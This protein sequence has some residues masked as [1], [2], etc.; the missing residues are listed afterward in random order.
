MKEV[1]IFPSKK[2]LFTDHRKRRLVRD[3][4]DFLCRCAPGKKWLLC[5]HK[6][7]AHRR[8]STVCLSSGIP[9]AASHRWETLHSFSAL[10]HRPRSRH[11]FVKE[12]VM[13]VMKA[14]HQND[15]SSSPFFIKFFL[16]GIFC[17][18]CK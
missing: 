14:I 2:F 5:G 11:F 4:I 13:T 10:C 12:A 18:K 1:F 3:A 6:R 15:A 7:P 8:T 17:C 16:Q 9:S